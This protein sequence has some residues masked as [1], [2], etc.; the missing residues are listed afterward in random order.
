[1]NKFII[2]LVVLVALIGGFFW[3][4]NYIYQEKQGLTDYKNLT[5]FLSGESVTLKDGYTETETVFGQTGKSVVGYFGNEAKGDLDGD[6]IPDL[7]FLITQET[8]GSGTFFYLVGALQTPQNTWNG[9][10]AVFIGDGIVPQTTEFRDLPD[11]T[12]GG[13]VIVNYADHAPG[14]PMTTKPSVGKSLYLKYDPET[15]DFGEV[16]QNFEGESAVVLTE[17]EARAIAE[18]SCIKGGESLAA[19]MHNRNT[20]TWWF[21]ANLNAT[22]PG[23]N[24]ACVVSEV[25]KTAE[26]NWRCTGLIEPS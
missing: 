16:A 24:P 10:H 3:V 22:R 14:E 23:C 19:G 20:Q 7:V 25:T 1:M 17:V 5:F 13:L 18:E 26:I 11:G 9:T 15:M 2:I 6:G 12:A 8:G 21:D 4:N